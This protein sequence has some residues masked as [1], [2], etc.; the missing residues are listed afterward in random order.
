MR[1]SVDAIVLVSVVKIGSDWWLA[2]WRVG[3]R[4]RVSG[5]F[6]LKLFHVDMNQL[7]YD[8]PASH[9]QDELWKPVDILRNIVCSWYSLLYEL[10]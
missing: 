1:E 5:R 7:M 8:E 3:R 4:P 10:S 9:P 2:Y 6:L